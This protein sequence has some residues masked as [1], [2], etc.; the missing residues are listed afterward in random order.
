[1]IWGFV[2]QEEVGWL[3]G[4]VNYMLEVKMDWG[5]E[6]VMDRAIFMVMDTKGGEVSPFVK[7]AFDFWGM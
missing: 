5:R 1:M 4:E 7:F 6:G 3:Q 2:R